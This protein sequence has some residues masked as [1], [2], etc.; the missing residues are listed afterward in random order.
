MN[1]ESKHQVSAIFHFRPK[2]SRIVAD[3][4]SQS[5]IAYLCIIL[6]KSVLKLEFEIEN[7][8]KA[9]GV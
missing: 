4:L 8:S 5:L 1:V 7:R 6:R 2:P 3:I 9:S